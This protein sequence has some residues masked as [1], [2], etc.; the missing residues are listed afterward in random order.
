MFTRVVTMDRRYILRIV[1]L[2]SV[3][4]LLG[5]AC[6]INRDYQDSWVLEGLEIPFVIFAIIFTLTFLSEKKLSW[7]IVLAVVGH[8]VFL[9]IPNL[10]YVWFQGIWVDQ[11]QQYALA[12]YVVGNGHILTQGFFGADVYGP[13]PLIHLLFSIFSIVLNVPLVCA[14]KYVP[15]LLSPLY[16]LLIYGIMKRLNLPWGATGLK[17][18]LFL[19]SI[20]AIPSYIITGTSFGSIFVLL[21][22]YFVIT[23]IKCQSRRYIFLFIFFVFTLTI[24]HNSSSLLFVIFI[25]GVKLLQ[26]ISWFRLKSYLKLSLVLAA[27]AIVAAWLLVPARFTFNA[28]V[29]AIM[30]GLSGRQNP[31]GESIPSRFFELANVNMRGAIDT[32]LVFYGADIL[33]LAMTVICLI[34]LIKMRKQNNESLNFLLVLAVIVVTAGLVGIPLGVG[35]FRILYFISL[36]FTIFCTIAILSIIKRKTWVHAAILLLIVFV[37]TLQFYNC[38]PLLPSANVLSQN[39][40]AEEPIVYVNSVNSVYQ[41]QLI[42][43]A[44]NHVAGKIACDAV[45]ENQILGLVDSDFF[46]NHLWWYY[47]PLDKTAAALQYDCF[48]IHLP[49]VSGGFIEQA[50]LRNH[51]V[52]LNTIYSSNVVYTNGESFVLTDSVP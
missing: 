7:M 22:L 3:I 10:K 37:S 17:Y 16:P 14:F 11:H 5:T 6:L 34:F 28:I 42:I 19:S 26:K 45:T 1:L 18:A 50:E 27:T 51:D 43:F 44:E 23:L 49:G 41:R 2:L 52:I 48:L 47:Y 32:A 9:L 46:V 24:A 21:A 30:E 38:Q 33:F 40:P 39:L 20:A 13:T 36:L 12:N 15:V 35:G 8:A 25:V 4:F 29:A 31:G